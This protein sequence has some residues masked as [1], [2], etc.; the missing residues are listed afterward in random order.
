[1]SYSLAGVGILELGQII[2]G[3]YGGQILSDLG[4]EVGVLERLKIDYPTISAVNPRI[5]QCSITGFG[6]SGIY[7]NYHALDINIQAINGRSGWAFR[8]PI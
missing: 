2:A 7:K 1:M 4:A 8:W 5:I 3:T 6:S